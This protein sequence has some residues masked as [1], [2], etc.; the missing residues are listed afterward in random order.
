[1]QS[2]L[3]VWLPAGRQIRLLDGVRLT[4]G[5]SGENDLALDADTEVSRVHAVLEQ[6]GPS[7]VVR[8]LSSRNG[9]LVNGERI[10]GDRPLTTGDELRIGATRM[11]YRSERPEQLAPT[12]GA[13]PRERDVLIALFAPALE[14]GAFTEPAGT[15]EIAAALVISEAAVKQHLS[16]LFEKFDIGPE[17]DRRRMRLANEALARG[18]ISLAEVRAK[19]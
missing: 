19:A 18:A 6:V 16:N 4:V 14:P 1:V 2:F 5:R 11:T 8:D 15:R 7:W 10:A 9:T 12:V 3:E 13:K 17:L